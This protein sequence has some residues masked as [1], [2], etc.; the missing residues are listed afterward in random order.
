M[1][2]RFAYPVVLLLLFV[3]V[4]WLIFALWRKPTGITYS[5]T[6]KMA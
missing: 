4:G 2:F 3:V 1:M 6:S 5:M